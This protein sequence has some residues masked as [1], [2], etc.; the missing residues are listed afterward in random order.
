MYLDE[1]DS[2]CYRKFSSRGEV[3]NSALFERVYQENKTFRELGF[4][5]KLEG[6]TTT[7]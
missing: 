3:G 4:A 1:F 2:L 5:N 6:I 7:N